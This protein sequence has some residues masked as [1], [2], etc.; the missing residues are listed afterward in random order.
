M[1]FL[2]ILINLTLFTGNSWAGWRDLAAS[3]FQIAPMPSFGSA[4]DLV[5]LQTMID[6]KK[7]GHRKLAIT[8][9]T[10]STMIL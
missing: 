4:E 1:R 10:I 5:D 9:T 6:V 2:L 8:L 7:T 3:Q